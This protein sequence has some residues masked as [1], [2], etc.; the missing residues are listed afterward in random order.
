MLSTTSSPASLPDFVSTTFITWERALVPCSIQLFSGRPDGT[1]LAGWILS[2]DVF[3]SIPNAST[4]WRAC[5]DA[6]R[7]TNAE[8]AGIRAMFTNERQ[9][10]S[11]LR[12][13]IFAS[14][15]ENILALSPDF[16]HTGPLGTASIAIPTLMVWLRG[17]YA[18]LTAS[19]LTS[20]LRILSEPWDGE[21]IER[22]IGQ[23]LHAHAVTA[24]PAYNQPLPEVQKVGLFLSAILPQDTDGT[25]AKATRDW[26]GLHPEVKDQTFNGD[27]GI[28][29]TVRKAI[30]TSKALNSH[31]SATSPQAFTVT[32]QTDPT[33]QK[34]MERLEQLETASRRPRAPPPKSSTSRAR[35]KYCWTHG[36]G[37]HTS[38][39]CNTPTEGHNV[40]AT[41]RDRRG[42]SRKGF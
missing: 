39:E 21:I 10:M 13:L 33:L 18:A 42:G 2:A 17:R 32:A 36:A 26:Y 38:A 1:G 30:A 16:D 37:Y 7:V 22:L 6:E 24:A 23:H 27:H 4:P 12:T 41:G 15:T 35:D 9:A 40:K 19:D 31:M 20:S 3:R 11:I 25:V 14:L 28:A 8:T 34:I 5:E 29:E